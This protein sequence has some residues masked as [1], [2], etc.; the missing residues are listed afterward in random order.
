MVLR[1]ESFLEDYSA[2]ERWVRTA[3]D[4]ELG[5]KSDEAIMKTLSQDVGCNLL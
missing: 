1:N 3:N 4:L 2:M 5:F